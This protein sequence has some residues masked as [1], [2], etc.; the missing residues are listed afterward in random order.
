MRQDGKTRGVEMNRNRAERNGGALTSR[1]NAPSDAAGTSSARS[2]STK[3]G[4]DRA[5]SAASG[6]GGGGSP[7]GTSSSDVPAVNPV[8]TQRG[9]GR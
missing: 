5:G 4:A 1:R 3:S 2:R 9:R 8:T 6:R 7:S